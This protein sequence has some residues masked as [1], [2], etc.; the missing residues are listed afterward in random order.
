MRVRSNSIAKLDW[1][2]GLLTETILEC[3]V[4]QSYCVLITIF[5][6]VLIL[7]DAVI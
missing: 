6:T 3:Q 5:D 7:H 2:H 4:S 1:Y